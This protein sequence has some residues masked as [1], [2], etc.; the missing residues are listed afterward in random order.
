MVHNFQIPFRSKVDRFG[1]LSVQAAR[2]DLYGGK[3]D[4][5]Q[6]SYLNPYNFSE[7]WPKSALL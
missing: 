2:W 5:G 4:F 1:I 3:K 7:F 6:I